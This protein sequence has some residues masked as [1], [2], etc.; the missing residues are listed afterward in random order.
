MCEHHD[1]RMRDAPAIKRFVEWLLPKTSELVGVANLATRC[2]FA[3]ATVG[4]DR[5]RPQHKAPLRGAYVPGRHARRPLQRVMPSIL[6]LPEIRG[7]GRMLSAP[8]GVL[9]Y[10]GVHTFV[11]RAIVLCAAKKI[12]FFSV[13]WG[14][15][16]ESES[17]PQ[18]Q[19]R[20]QYVCSAY[21]SREL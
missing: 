13:V 3:A 12:L 8:T 16:R 20:K 14:M 2:G 5:I 6:V 15:I 1:H 21:Q 19:R 18:T 10:R 9:E 11:T 17:I 7:C 4:A